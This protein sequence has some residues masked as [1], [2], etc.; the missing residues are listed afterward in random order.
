[1]QW[2]AVL[3]TLGRFCCCITNS[4]PRVLAA[5]RIEVALCILY[6]E[7]NAGEFPQRS[8]AASR[9]KPNILLSAPALF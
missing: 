4:L 9:E 6:S 5:L 8:A 3:E 1:V 7:N 2:E